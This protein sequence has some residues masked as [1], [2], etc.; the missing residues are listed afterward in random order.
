MTV[1][2]SSSL[3]AMACAL[4]V[5][6]YF[7]PRAVFLFVVVWPKMLCIMAGMHLKVSYAL[8]GSGL[9]KARFFLYF[10]P[11][12]VFLPWLSGPVALSAGPPLGVHLGRYGPE[13]QL[14]C[15]M[16]VVILV[17]TQRLIPTVLL[18]VEIS[19]LQF[20]DKVIDVPGM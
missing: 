16:V 1:R 9:C 15:E 12:A 5:H 17:V 18:T 20:L 10:T 19:Q 13:G 7:T 3:S 11:R 4:L 2:R 6:W 14:Y 8:F